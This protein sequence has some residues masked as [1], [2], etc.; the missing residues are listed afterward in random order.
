M[1]LSRRVGWGPAIAR[2]AGRDLRTRLVVLACAGVLGCG[3]SSL[4]RLPDVVEIEARGGAAAP[5][6]ALGFVVEADGF[7][8]TT[9]RAL[10]DPDTGTLR[11]EIEVTLWENGRRSSLRGAVVGVE[12]T[13][14]LAILALD[15]GRELRPERIAS[16]ARVEPGQLVSAV[17]AGRDGPRTIAGRI[18]AL[19][20]KECYQESLTDTLV[21]AQID[22]PSVAA[23]APIRSETGEIVAIHTGYR[24]AGYRVSETRSADTRARRSLDTASISLPGADAPAPDASESD[25]IDHPGEVHLLPIQLAMNIYQGVKQRGSVRSPWTGF[26]VRA[27]DPEERAYFPTDRRHLGG[28]AI[29]FVWER[30]PA[31]ELGIEVGDLLVKLGHYPVTSVDDFQRWL[32]AYGVG[33]E[34][35]L[36]LLRGGAEYKELRYVIEERPSWA[37]PR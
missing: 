35:E 18:S 26:S 21:R 33:R 3:A 16:G 7:V 29:E 24:P 13:L 28:V 25:H 5:T 22:L 4:D 31:D 15:A 32:Y 20:V 37:K 9:Y 11:D 10:V 34:V 19:N 14:D 17:V 1:S 6:R 23:G 8:L 30:S 12:P 36:V 27:L 2:H